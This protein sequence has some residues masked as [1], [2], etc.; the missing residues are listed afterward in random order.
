M[1]NF[2]CVTTWTGLSFAYAKWIS[3]RPPNVQSIRLLC[4]RLFRHSSD[5]GST[6]FF[7]LFFF[8][9]NRI[10]RDALHSICLAP[11]VNNDAEQLDVN[12]GRNAR[13]QKRRRRK[14]NSGDLLERKEKL[15]FCATFNKEEPRPQQVF[16]FHNLRRGALRERIGLIGYLN[17]P[18]AEA[19][20]WAWCCSSAW[21]RH[22]R[23]IA[24]WSCAAAAWNPTTPSG[25]RRQSASRKRFGSWSDAPASGWG[26]SGWRRRRCS[27]G[28]PRGRCCCRKRSTA[29]HN[30]QKRRVKHNTAAAAA[31][32]EPIRSHS[33]PVRYYSL[34]RKSLPS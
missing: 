11:I 34:G 27:G 17:R 25:P 3:T 15:M 21:R 9:R 10:G 16:F 2:G 12:T 24:V 6:T 20:R 19:G 22:I 26:P 18:E 13:W 4:P 30:Q 1:Y 28:T 23:A 8:F 5:T 29:L 31:A 33:R 32:A 7:I 14:T